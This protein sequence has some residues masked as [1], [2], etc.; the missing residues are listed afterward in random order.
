MIL[1]VVNDAGPAKYLAYIIKSLN[2]IAYECISSDISSKVFDE[3]SVKHSLDD[4]LININD[5]HL[6]ITGT[7]LNDG[8]DKKWLNIAKQNR[9]KVISII[10]H[11][12][13]YKKRFELNKKYF[14]PD[15]IYVNDEV[16][17]KEAIED[18]IDKKLLKVVGN[19]V[20]ENIKLD[21]NSQNIVNSSINKMG[22]D[23]NKK[24]ITFVS[25]EYKKDFPKESS[26]YQGFDEFEVLDDILEV[27]PFEYNLIIKLHPSENEDK[28]DYLK[29]AKNVIII[30]KID[31]SLLF[32]LSDI[33][34]GM[35]SMLLIEASLVK[36]LVYSY[37]PNEKIEFIG[38]KNNMT[39]KLN[40]KEN[41][42]KIFNIKNRVRTL[43]NMFK[44]STQRIQKLIKE[45]L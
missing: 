14:Y 1:F 26:Y 13:L 5:Y 44:G 40:N 4:S 42:K 30:K 28:Y 22:I 15:I 7:C 16:A 20:L 27:M 38:N 23:V 33:I 43:N 37:R 36:N 9:V 24:I 10:E 39:I 18:G 11:W 31:I 35:G 41:L 32:E 19:P 45:E 34:I 2:D 29:T 6:V 21:K 3:F 25:E 8:I 12:S 17:K